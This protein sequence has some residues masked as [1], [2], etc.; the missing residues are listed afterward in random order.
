MNA[1]RGMA[2]RKACGSDGLPMELYIG[3]WEVL[4]QDLYDVLNA[5]YASGS[6]SLSQRPGIISLVCKRG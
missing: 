1:L 5:Y 2:R 3:F 4:G 6:L